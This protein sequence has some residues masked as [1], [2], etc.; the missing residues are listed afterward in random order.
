MKILSCFTVVMF[1][2]FTAQA[3][4]MTKIDNLEASLKGKN[5]WISWKLDNVPASDYWEVQGS[6]DGQSFLII[7]LVLGSKPGTSSEYIFK[8]DTR[9]MKKDLKY[10][11]V[12]QIQHDQTAVAYNAVMVK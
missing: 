7:G 10:F 9:Q 4:Q 5:V 2:L 3:Q 12:L 6:A 11:R 8:G 1:L